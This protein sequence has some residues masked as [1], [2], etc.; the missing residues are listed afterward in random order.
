MPPERFAPPPTALRLE[1]EQFAYFVITSTYPALA[2]KELTRSRARKPSALLSPSM[3]ELLTTAEMAEADRRTIASGTAGIE[4]MENAGRAVAEAVAARHPPGVRVAVVAGPGNNGGDGFVTARFLAERGY[5]VRVL[6]VGDPNRL[7][8]D[9]A[10]AAQRWQ[11]PTIAAAPAALTPA[12]IVIDAL[13]GAGL[14]RRVEGV[15]RAMIEAMNAAPCV[16]AVDLPSGINGTTGAVMGLAV[17]A[18]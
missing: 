5:R 10:L 2:A 4:L 7:K 13:F 14:D 8:G 16:Y 15:A 18:A 17:N 11:G 9:G 1:F 6:L 3:L 12:D